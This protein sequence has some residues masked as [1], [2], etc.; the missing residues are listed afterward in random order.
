MWNKEN[1]WEN[2]TVLQFM[3]Q[4]GGQ[5]R[6]WLVCATQLEKQI[7]DNEKRKERKK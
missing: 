5:Q 4:L 6:V 1:L 3:S 2:A 7:L